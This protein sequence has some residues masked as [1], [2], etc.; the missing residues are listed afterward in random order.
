M[1]KFFTIAALGLLTL[2][3]YAPASF[4]GGDRSQLDKGIVFE[5]QECPEGETWS[6]EKKA[7]EKKTEVK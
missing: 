1:T 3:L 5:K 2:N 7:C 6:E 4:A